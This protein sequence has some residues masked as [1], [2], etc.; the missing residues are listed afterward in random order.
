MQ[1][2]LVNVKFENVSK[3]SQRLWG[4]QVT[5]NL[6]NFYC[7]YREVGL[8]IKKLRSLALHKRKHMA[9]N[10]IVPI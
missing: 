1:S 3:M 7:V 5:Q 8:K 10:N 4:H 6:K 9:I 2:N